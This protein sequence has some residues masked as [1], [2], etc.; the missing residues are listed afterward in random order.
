MVFQTVLINGQANK[1]TTGALKF[2]KAVEMLH[3]TCGFIENYMQSI[4]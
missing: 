4:N 2:E 3:A 1:S